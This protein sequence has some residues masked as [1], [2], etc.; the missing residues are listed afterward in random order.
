MATAHCPTVNS[1]PLSPSLGV[2]SLR[3]LCPRKDAWILVAALFRSGSLRSM[4]ANSSSTWKQNRILQSYFIFIVDMISQANMAVGFWVL[5]SYEQ[6]FSTV[7][8][9][10]KYPFS[11]RHI[12][13][14]LV[15]RTFKWLTLKLRNYNLHMEPN[16]KIMNEDLN[17]IPK[18]YHSIG[19]LF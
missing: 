16:K 8:H 19:T 7:L 18:L 5:T 6:Y 11:D 3:T 9:I 12:V 14:Y 2:P 15:A 17:H 4:S 13:Q 10:Q 1:S